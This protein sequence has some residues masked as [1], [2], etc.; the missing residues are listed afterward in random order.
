M[1]ARPRAHRCVLVW[2]A[3]PDIRNAKGL[4]EPAA[5]ISTVCVFVTEISAEI[6]AAISDQRLGL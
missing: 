4:V 1:T 3:H 5:L 2:C 6:S